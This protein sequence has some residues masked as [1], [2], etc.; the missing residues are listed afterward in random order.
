MDSNASVDS[1]QAEINRLQAE[2]VNLKLKVCVCRCVC[3]CVN[4]C[5]GLLLFL[6]HCVC[7][8][9]SQSDP[10]F[11]VGCRE[12]KVCGRAG[13]YGAAEEADGQ[14]GVSAY[15]VIDVLA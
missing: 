3:V 2:N 8:T 15:Q 1:Q 10:C 14:S 4:V 13:R 5:L 12:A 11:A 7:S 6:V 9:A